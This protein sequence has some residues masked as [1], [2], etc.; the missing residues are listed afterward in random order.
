LSLGQQSVPT[1]CVNLPALP[2]GLRLRY[3]SLDGRICLYTAKRWRHLQPRST[4]CRHKAW[5]RLPTGEKRG[6]YLLLGG[7]QRSHDPGVYRPCFL[8]PSRAYQTPDQCALLV[9]AK[10]LSD[11]GQNE[12][13]FT[14]QVIVVLDAKYDD[15]TQHLA[16]QTWRDSRLGW[17]RLQKR[18]T[19]SEPQPSGAWVT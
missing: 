19:L 4:W 7:R 16:L 2:H 6:Q 1:A 15:M 8:A 18:R 12:V 9:L 17:E 11:E 14:F 13:F 10:P 5:Q 3:G